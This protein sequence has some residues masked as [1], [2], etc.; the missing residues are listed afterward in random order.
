MVEI[1][2]AVAHMWFSLSLV[3]II[4][5]LTLKFHHALEVTQQSLSHVPSTNLFAVV[6]L[7]KVSVSNQTGQSYPL[8]ASKYESSDLLCPCYSCAFSTGDLCSLYS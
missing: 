2:K 7:N 4:N 8:V 5:T 6:S 1:L 3:F